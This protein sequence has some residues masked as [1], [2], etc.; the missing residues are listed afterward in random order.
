M[1]ETEFSLKCASNLRCKNQISGLPICQTCETCVLS[2][3]IAVTKEWFL[4]A[5]EFSQRK[6]VLGIV[7][8]LECLDLLLSVESVLQPVLGKDFTY[9]RSRINPSLQEDAHTTGSD[10]ALNPQLWQQFVA[11]TWRW[12]KGGTT[13]SKHNYALL[14]LK[15]CKAH[16]L[17]SVA[18]LIHVL[19]VQGVH[20]FL[21]KKGKLVSE[22]ESLRLGE[23]L[24]YYGMKDPEHS[25]LLHTIDDPCLMVVPSSFKA[26]S[27]V[28]KYKDFIQGLPVHLSKMIL[29]FLD[30]KSLSSCACVSH[31]WCFMIKDL[32]RD[33]GAKKMIQN[34]AMILRGTSSR[35]VN[36][37]YAK[38][39]NVPIPKIGDD[40]NAILRTEKKI[41]EK[42]PGESLEAA[43]IDNE[44]ET[45]LMEERNVY[46]GPYNVLMLS[47]HENQHKAIHFDGGQFVA[48]GAADRKV[49]L[50][51]IFNMK[52]VPPL[53]NG[54]A[55]S[56]HVVHL[57]EERG[58][59]FSGGYDLSIRRWNLQSGV[60]MKIYLG[61]MRTIT[62]LDVCENVLVS[63]AKDR[64]IKVWNLTSGK[65]FK[66]FK[67][68]DAI[69]DVKIK[70]QYVVSGCDRGIVKIWNLESATLIK[71]LSGHDGPVKCLVFDQWHLLSGGADGYAI[72]WSM[73][74]TVKK[75]LM[76]FRHPKEVTC[77]AFV[78]LRVITGCADGKIRVF[79]FLGGDCLREMSA[80]SR[81]DP[82]LSLCVR[83]NRMVINVHSSIMIFQFEEISWD[84]SQESVRFTV[85]KDRYHFKLA[86]IKA[87]PYSYVRAQRMR[88][89]GSSDRKLYR[90]EQKLEHDKNWLSH[91]ARSLSARSMKRAQDLHEESLKPIAWPDLQNFHRSFAYID[92]QPEFRKKIPSATKSPDVFT[93]ASSAG[94]WITKDESDAESGY[95][96]H[97][98]KSALSRSEDA[99]LKRIKQRGPHSPLNP[100]EI[101][102]KVSTIQ[103]L[104]KLDVL[105]SNLKHNANVHSVQGSSV[106]NA[107]HKQENVHCHSTEPNRTDPSTALSK[108]QGSSVP[109]E[110]NTHR[111]QSQMR[112][113]TLQGSSEVPSSVLALTTA[114]PTGSYS[115][116]K[117]KGTS[118]VNRRSSSSVE[119]GIQQLG[120][121][122][123]CEAVQP[124]R[125][126]IGQIKKEHNQK[127]KPELTVTADPFREKSGFQLL[128]VKQLEAYEAQ[129][130]SQFNKI[131]ALEK[132]SRLKERKKER[133]MKI[134]GQITE[135]FN[136]NYK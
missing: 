114:H 56:I 100:T 3:K 127:K 125:M 64:Q 124:L 65:C 128:T 4:R 45:V 68:K 98:C 108:T 75:R 69:S 12:F 33:L 136:D 32:L 113:M 59:V 109:A 115:N 92:L 25:S 15:M 85:P 129:T 82:V 54:H 27:G 105:S 131:E 120:L 49:K 7:R 22:D 116:S 63:G 26:T 97:R 123:S 96:S 70:G 95:S 1:K 42:K 118:P 111:K 78:Y 67:H 93:R 24:E 40:G 132:E 81:A 122:T 13:W 10:R 58:F 39:Q 72:A 88:H 74:G 110:I 104:E 126:V 106:S 99:T 57:C 90:Q 8:R 48:V 9:S 36:V 103:N 44:T 53:F 23:L 16:L 61:H 38:I 133:I 52:Q 21:A 91:H 134:N 101:L 119:D 18:N 112:N 2:T 6:F 47:G 94:E 89:I 83:D 31:H 11:E 87:R 80:N 37:T 41:I 46:C 30:N 73:L 107:Q 76:T 130:V 55:G 29:G 17:H 71:S 66:T 34:D 102:L 117:K 14:L 28:R 60:C 50:L 84:Y 135:K 86:P 20:S 121:Y 79:N 19:V 43:Y 77:L 51:D 5:G 62:C 35:G